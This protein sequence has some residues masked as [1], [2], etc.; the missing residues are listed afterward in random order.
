MT[1]LL[2]ILFFFIVCVICNLSLVMA[3]EKDENKALPK[4]NEFTL[5]DD[6]V[7]LVEL[8]ISAPSKAH[9]LEQRLMV[10][11]S[12]LNAAEQYLILL[13]KANIK[14][15]KQQ[16]QDVILL[17]ED[18]KL[19]SKY[20]AEKQLDLPLF[21]HSYLVLASSYVAI[22]DYDNAYQN[23]KAFVDS[24]ND[25]SD[26]ERENTVNK[27]T[28]KYE[29]AHKIEANKLLAN[30]NKLKELRISDVHRLQQDLQ[31]KFMLI[32]GTILLFALLFLR[33]LKVRRKLLL[34]SKTDSLTGLLNRAALLQ[35]GQEL[36]HIYSQQKFELS[37]L[38]F[39]ID[40]FKSINDEFGHHVGDLALKKIA[41]LVN[42]TMRA[43]DTF[44]RLGGEEFVVILPHTDLAKAKAIAVRVMEKIAQYDFSELGA[45]RSITLSIGVANI[46]DTDT[47]FDDIL[48]AADLA[49]YQAKAQGRNQMVSYESI[50]KDQERRQR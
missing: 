23:K 26:T 17:I 25:Y 1:K 6:I 48:H 10:D 14:Q 18:A 28:Q 36:V 7:A 47:E 29:V 39:D 2:T 32:I 34:L 50:A 9:A 30:Q 40:Y 41:R 38:L 13:A 45:N 20:I 3:N 16:H 42:E 49:M 43:R 22:K 8:S 12:T 5:R 33:Q 27:L 11:A 24:Y 46:K 31:H 15:H 21:S 37:V 44:A 35:E 19:L 4:V